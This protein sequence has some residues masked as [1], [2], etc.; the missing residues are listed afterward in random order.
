MV[1]DDRGLSID[2]LDAEQLRR[3]ATHAHEEGHDAV[4]DRMA[5]I[6]DGV[7]RAVRDIG[8]LRTEAALVPEMLQALREVLGAAC[9]GPECRFCGTPEGEEHDPDCTMQFVLAALAK[10]EPRA[11]WTAADVEAAVPRNTRTDAD[12]EDDLRS[13]REEA[14][15]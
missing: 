11:S 3:W 1:S 4:A 9:D 13:L 12:V 6:A 10:G 15:Q 7:E 2:M 8:Q 14:G 5:G